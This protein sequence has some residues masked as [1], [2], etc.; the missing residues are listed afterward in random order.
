MQFLTFL[1]L[2][3]TIVTVAFHT[4]VVSAAPYSS[5]SSFSNS[6]NLKRS[7]EPKLPTNR[8]ERGNMI[9]GV[10]KSLFNPPPPP[11]KIYPVAPKGGP[12]EPLS[13][14]TPYQV[15]QRKPKNV[16]KLQALPDGLEAFGKWSPQKFNELEPVLRKAMEEQHK[17][18]GKWTVPPGVE[19]GSDEYKLWLAI[20]EHNGLFDR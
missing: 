4:V 5:R 9:V 6:N 1:M 2:C 12:R 18:T 11:E 10:L 16:T 20:M 13:Q 17:E 8:G 14:S 15:Y 3:V 19:Q 7:G